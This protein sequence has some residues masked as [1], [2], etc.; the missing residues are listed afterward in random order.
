MLR[1]IVP[2]VLFLLP[3]AAQGQ[4]IIEAR[5]AVARAEVPVSR[6]LAARPSAAKSRDDKVGLWALGGAV[7][8]FAVAAKIASDNYSECEDFCLL[9][10]KV[11]VIWIS[12]L[13][14]G[15]GGLVGAAIGTIVM[16]GETKALMRR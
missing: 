6:L 7:V 16:R 9:P 12:M 4:R 15:V 3:S 11:H 5:T 2:F 10:P 8:G 1:W 14:A 13:G